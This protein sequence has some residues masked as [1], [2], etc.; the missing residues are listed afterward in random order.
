MLSPSPI[1]ERHGSRCRVFAKLVGSAFFLIF[2]FHFKAFSAFE[3]S[4]SGAQ[5]V[6]FST[7]PSSQHLPLSARDTIMNRCLLSTTYTRQKPCRPFLGHVQKRFRSGV[8]P[9]ATQVVISDAYRFVYLKTRKTAGTTILYG[10]LRKLMCAPKKGDKLVEHFWNKTKDIPVRANCSERILSPSLERRKLPPHISRIPLKKLHNYFVF[11]TARNPYERA[12]SSYEYCHLRL[13]GS[14]REFVSQPLTFG[15]R[16]PARPNETFPEVTKA[17]FHWDPQIQ[18]MCD[19]TG[20]NCI[21]DYVVDT[22]NITMMMD[23]VVKEINKRRDKL[24]PPLPKFSDS[25]K[26]MNENKKKKSYRK[27]YK[28]CKDCKDLVKEYYLEDVTMFG[29]EFPY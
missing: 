25:F 5:T 16:C 9:L 11:T 26:A 19:S 18:E 3:V 15:R 13:V 17:N 27:Y 22:S 8:L 10:Y 20:I 4:N 12:V 2:L 29:Y 6:S 28:D 14:F 21:V 7:I 24:Y 1:V 23:E